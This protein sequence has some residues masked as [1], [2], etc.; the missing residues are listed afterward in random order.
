MAFRRGFKTEAVT[1]ADEVRREL[2][3]EPMDALDPRELAAFLCIPIWALSDFLDD[4]PNIAHLYDNEPA[5]FSA[6]T[7]FNGH[8]RTIVHNDAHSPARQTSNLAHELAHGLLHHPPTPAID[9]TGSRNWNQDVEDEAG[10]LSGALLVTEAVTL[11]IARNQMT[12]QQAATLLGV[13]AQM[14]Q[15]RLNSTGAMKRA[16]R[17][18][19][20]RQE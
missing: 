20:R 18:T 3:L 14:I 10:Y 11:A 1:A 13:S 15:F 16:E 5:L 6:V 12:R 9:D 2:G 4:G 19:R 17:A 7:V 8:E